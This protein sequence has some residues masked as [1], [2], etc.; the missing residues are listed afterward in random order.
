MNV[1]LAIIAPALWVAFE[2]LRA[3][4]FFLSAPW[5]LLG[6]SQYQNIPLLQVTSLTGVYGLSFLIVLVNACFAQFLLL[7]SRKDERGQC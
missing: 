1:S 6:H 2:F 3:N 7:F 5:F 4:A